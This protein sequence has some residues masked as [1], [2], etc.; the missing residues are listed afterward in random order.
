MYFCVIDQVFSI[1][2]GVMFILQLLHDQVGVV[3]FQ[4]YK[5][6]FMQTFA[7]A[8]TCYTALPSLPPLFGYPHRN[9][10]VG[11]FI[12]LCV[13]VFVCVCVCVCVCKCGYVCGGCNN[14]KMYYLSQMAEHC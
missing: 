10:Y 11:C 5:Q 8:R 12:L 9:W 13:H 14:V 7:R 3:E 4:S 2:M 6:L 1:N